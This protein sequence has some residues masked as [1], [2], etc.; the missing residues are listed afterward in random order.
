MS[1]SVRCLD[2]RRIYPNITSDSPSGLCTCPA[3]DGYKGP[4]LPG[5]F[6]V[7]PWAWLDEECDLSTNP[8]D[9]QRNDGLSLEDGI[10]TPS[11]SGKR[12]AARPAPSV[13]ATSVTGSAYF[14]S[15]LKIVSCS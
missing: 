6:R 15:I 10:T 1:R 8:T 3:P 14:D 5:G 12:S 2:C 11:S 4:I 7:A 13:S 9:S